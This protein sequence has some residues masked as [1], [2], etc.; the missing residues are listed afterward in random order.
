MKTIKDVLKLIDIRLKQVE[1]A[2][3]SRSC[4]KQQY[5]WTKNELK[6]L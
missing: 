5:Y 1:R 3:R 4:R 2:F 6:E